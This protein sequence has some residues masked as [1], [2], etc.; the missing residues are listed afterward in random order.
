M[1]KKGW[2]A[3]ES[4]I[5]AKLKENAARILL[6][7]GGADSRN[8]LRNYLTAYQVREASN[9]KDALKLPFEQ[10]PDLVLMN[11]RLSGIDGPELLDHL[12]DLFPLLPILDLAEYADSQEVQQYNFDEFI[13]KPVAPEQL[14][15]LI[16]KTLSDH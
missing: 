2:S 9:N 8:L 10:E 1:R 14:I 12:R 3:A 13:T 16:E 4:L 11:F 6:V 15:E 7:E 5:D